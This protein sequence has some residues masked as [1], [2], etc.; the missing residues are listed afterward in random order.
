[1]GR[2]LAGCWPEGCHQRPSPDG[3]V[4]AEPEGNPGRLLHAQEDVMAPVPIILYGDQ[5]WRA[6]KTSTGR[7]G[8]RGL[9]QGDREER[10]GEAMG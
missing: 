4:A 8:P 2:S 6:V 10:Y 5:A 3:L 7:A 9:P 1:M